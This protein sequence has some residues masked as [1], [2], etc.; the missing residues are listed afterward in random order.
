MDNEILQEILGEL[1]NIKES[2]AV[3]ER[4]MKDMKFMALDLDKVDRHLAVVEQGQSKLE[5]GQAELKDDIS[6]LKAGQAKLED[7]VTLVRG[8][9]VVI[10]NEHGKKLESLWDGHI[11][12]QETL[13]DH[14]VVLKRIETRSRNGCGI[15]L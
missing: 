10:E 7:D 2:Q 14:S 13:G 11:S 3:L 12:I 9:V 8:S 5:R 15:F 6:G 4:D 1:K